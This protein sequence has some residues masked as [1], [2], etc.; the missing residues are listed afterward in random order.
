MKAVTK[1]IIVSFATIPSRISLIEP[2]INSLLEQSMAPD[3]IHIQIPT[4]CK[5]TNSGFKIPKFLHKYKSNVKLKVREKDFGAMNKSYYPLMDYKGRSDILI[6]VV[7]DDCD[8]KDK[9]IE[10]LYK[11]FLVQEAAYCFSGGI[12]PKKPQ[13]FDKIGIFKTVQKDTFTFL[14]NNKTDLE[15]DTVQG[16]GM[17]ILNPLWFEK[18]D[19]GE[20]VNEESVSHNDDIVISSLLEKQKIKRIQVGPY[21]IPNILAQSEIDPIHGQGRLIS[22][23]K[24]ALSMV[25]EKL[26]VWND[27][28][29]VP[30]DPT[31]KNNLMQTLKNVIPNKLKLKI[32][33]ILK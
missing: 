28:D 9:S 21:Y 5:K 16:F 31:K 15:V 8:Y 11:K 12:F 29:N 32:K 1:S 6:F 4:F 19:L 26:N 22:M 7:D 30:I 24:S 14:V 20:V 27:I 2:V 13:I 18:M 23:T 17:Y 10:K 33:S 3:E 25:Q